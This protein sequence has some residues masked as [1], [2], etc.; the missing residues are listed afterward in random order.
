MSTARRSGRSRLRQA[1][2]HV[3][4]AI[5]GAA[6]LIVTAGCGSGSQ[7]HDNGTRAV[8]IGIDGADWKVIDA[9]AAEGGMPNLT[10]LR[11]SGV[12]GPI[13]TLHD[14]A[15]SI[16]GRRIFRAFALHFVWACGNIPALDDLL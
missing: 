1:G 15:L 8:I 12:W 9:L 6:L 11:A 7:V 3:R 10:R 4:L 5:A 16:F 2:N 14:I 13:D